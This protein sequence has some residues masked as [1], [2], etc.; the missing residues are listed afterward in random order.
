[1]S[2]AY[3][4]LRNLHARLRQLEETL[5]AER[6]QEIIRA[7]EF[8]N[9]GNDV[10]ASYHTGLADGHNSMLT[11]LHSLASQFTDKRAPAEEVVP[12]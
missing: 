8:K 5:K 2:A 3:A 9:Q 6:Q 12:E 11:A 4:T 10:R 7:V 1:M